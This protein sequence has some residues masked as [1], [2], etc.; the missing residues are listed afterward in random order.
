MTTNIIDTIYGRLASMTPTD[1]KI[2]QTIL[3][4][5]AAIV[6][7]TISQLATTAGVSDAS[8][9]R[10]CRNLDLAGFHQLKVKVAQAAEDTSPAH[11]TNN[12][13]VQQYLVSVT[14]NKVDEVT[15]SLDQLSTA[16]I[17]QLVAWLSTASVIQVVAD[18]DTYPVA[19][20]AT[21]KFNQIGLF[22]ISAQPWETAV[23]QTLNL[24]QRAVLIAISNSGE[25]R[26]MLKTVDVAQSRGVRV[27]GIT[28][29]DDSP[30]AQRADL[31]ITTTVRQRVLRSEYY[32]SRVA[33]MTVI[34]ALY[35]L[36]IH[37]DPERIE[38]IHTHEAIIADSKV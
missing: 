27:I 7:W 16:L 34:E 30:L 22:A 19:A 17:D 10:F 24:D 32:F 4:Q 25:S 13:D 2:A 23:A 6:D 31:H 1:Q 15:H 8:V 28:N 20:D 38:R 11:A 12:D 18:G 14:A 33:A 29:R 9:S 21:Y 36:L 35:L 5:P 37:A 26:T 3:D